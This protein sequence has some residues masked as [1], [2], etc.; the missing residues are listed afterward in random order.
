MTTLVNVATLLG[1]AAHIANTVSTGKTMAKRIIFTPNESPEPKLFNEILVD[2]TWVAGLA[3][4]QGQKSVSNLHTSALGIPGINSILE[5]STRSLDPLGLSMS[6]FNL[7]LF[8]AGRKY[9]VEAVYQ[10]SKVFRN[11]GPFLDLLSASSLDAKRD[12]RLKSSGELIGFSFE[13]QMWPISS[14]PNFYDYLYIRAL[15][16]NSRRLDLIR[17][18][19]FSDLAFNQITIKP[20]SGKS[21]NCQAR[22]AAI[23]SSLINRMPEEEILAWISKEFIK[24][25]DLNDQLE[26]F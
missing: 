9:A 26:M 4:S 20:K 14:A 23:Y 10:S 8:H 2:F 16:E 15:L 24:S 1:G 7:T 13:S 21:F 19:A 12:P 17:F 3:I 22:S 6:A 18:D 25:R 11:G 5:I